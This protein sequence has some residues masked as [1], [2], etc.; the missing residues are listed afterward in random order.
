MSQPV[1]YLRFLMNSIFVRRLVYIYVA[2]KASIS[3][4]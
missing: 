4:L 1:L 2:P 3:I